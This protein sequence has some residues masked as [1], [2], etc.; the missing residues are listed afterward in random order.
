MGGGTLCIYNKK[1]TRAGEI[2]GVGGGDE[3]SFQLRMGG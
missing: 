3:K 2:C 1:H